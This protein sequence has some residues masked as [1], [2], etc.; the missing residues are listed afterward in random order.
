M[1][2]CI[3]TVYNSVNSGSY[4]QAHALA[5]YFEKKGDKVYFYERPTGINASSS[6]IFRLNRVLRALFKFNIKRVIRLCHMYIGF[7]RCQKVFNIISPKRQDELANIDFFVLGSDTI[8]NIESSYFLENRSTFWGGRFLN[9]P[10]ISYAGSVANCSVKKCMAYPELKPMVNNWR[11]VGVRDEKTKEIISKLTDKEVCKVCDPTFLISRNEYAEMAP[12]VT[13]GSY[14]FLYLFE[15]LTSEYERQL[16]SFAKKNRLKI[17]SGLDQDRISDQ[18]LVNTPMTFL[19]Y[20]LSASYVITDTFH[21][22]AFSIN[23]EKNFV[24]IDR[25]KNKVNELLKM[26]NFSDRLVGASENLEK[27]FNTKIDYDERRS[28]INEFKEYSLNFLDNARESVSAE[29]S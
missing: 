26:L 21:G 9:V 10:V 17:I 24:V 4:W 25:N 12:S 19:R 20:M 8:W 2:I 13:E 15:D 23:L 5:T 7:A 6:K 3:V 11:F 16:K 27:L 18:V 22:T 1:N 14:I 28:I 29:F